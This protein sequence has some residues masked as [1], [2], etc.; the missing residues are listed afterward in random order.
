MYGLCFQLQFED[1][2]RARV[3]LRTVVTGHLS[4]VSDPVLRKLVP[5]GQKTEDIIFMGLN[6]FICKSRI[7]MFSSVFL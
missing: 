3:V 1:T 4:P 2:L 5:G 7:I 6:S